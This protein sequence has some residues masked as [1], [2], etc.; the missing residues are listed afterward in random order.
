M[1]DIELLMILLQEKKY[2]YF[3]YEELEAL[4]QSNNN[5]V[6]LT[7]SKLCL[8]KADGDKKIKVGP[9]EIEGPGATYW[10]NLSND[11]LL[12][13]KSK[14]TDTVSPTTGYKSMMLRADGQ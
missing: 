11:Y 1:A 5:D 12:T 14:N 10:I 9:V 7:A 8:M 2:S 6:Y 13:S 3:E 4:L